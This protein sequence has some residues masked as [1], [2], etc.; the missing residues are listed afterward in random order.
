MNL[1]IKLP[2]T[3]TFHFRC[4]VLGVNRRF[5]PYKMAVYLT[6]LRAS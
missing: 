4:T 2:P 5:E 6:D 3:F 1:P